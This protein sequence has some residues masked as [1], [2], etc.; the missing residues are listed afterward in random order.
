LCGNA[1]LWLCGDLGPW[2]CGIWVRACR[3]G[4]GFEVR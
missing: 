1:E 2:N 3:L 4:S